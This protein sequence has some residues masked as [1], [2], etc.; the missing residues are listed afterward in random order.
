M[1]KQFYVEK[2]II[3]EHENEHERLPQRFSTYIEA[4]QLKRKR[5][6]EFKNNNNIDFYIGFMDS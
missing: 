1:A 5:Q 4:L 3:Y 2:I 6:K